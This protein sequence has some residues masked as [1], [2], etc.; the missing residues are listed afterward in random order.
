MSY[1]N[2]Y[3]EEELGELIQDL[4]DSAIHKHFIGQIKPSNEIIL[5]KLK[6]DKHYDEAI[7]GRL[8]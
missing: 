3:D 8:G 4:N 2:W 5:K 1:M 7:L 6:E